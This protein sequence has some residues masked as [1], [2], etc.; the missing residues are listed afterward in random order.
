VANWHLTD[1]M[2]PD[3][4][5]AACVLLAAPIDVHEVVCAKV[6]VRT[7]K[8]EEFETVHRTRSR[9]SSIRF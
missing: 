6:E 2:M 1:K 8:S 9:S 4:G 3:A 7:G 5:G